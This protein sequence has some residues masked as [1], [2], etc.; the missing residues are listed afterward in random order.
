MHDEDVSEKEL[1]YIALLLITQS[2]RD[3]RL[4][5]LYVSVGFEITLASTSGTING[6]RFWWF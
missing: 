1:Y 2:Y 5:M 3:M 4:H 6:W